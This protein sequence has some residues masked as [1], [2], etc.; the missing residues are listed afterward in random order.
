MTNIQGY[1]N[2]LVENWTKKYEYTLCESLNNYKN[3]LNINNDS[4]NKY[5]VN[6]HFENLKTKIEKIPIPIDDYKY[7]VNKNKKN[8]INSMVGGR[9]VGQSATDRPILSPSRPAP[10]T[11]KQTTRKINRK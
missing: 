1:I 5:N 4:L 9:L 6:E 10:I 3:S 11:K 2:L 8:T 7:I